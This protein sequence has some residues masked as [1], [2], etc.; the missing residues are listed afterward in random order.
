MRIAPW[1]AMAITLVVLSA[2]HDDDDDLDTLCR[3]SMVSWDLDSRAPIWT[4]AIRRA[5]RTVRPATVID[6]GCGPFREGPYVSQVLLYMGPRGTYLGVDQ[7][8]ETIAR[9]AELT[10]GAARVSHSCGD[11]L[12]G[13]WP[14][15]DLAITKCFVCLFYQGDQ[16]PVV[17]KIRAAADWWLFYD[18]FNHPDPTSYLRS[19]GTVEF[20]I[21][22]CPGNPEYTRCGLLKF[23]R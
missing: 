1:V 10:R 23:L 11:F 16:A 18:S 9:H 17:E 13:E 21:E 4:D 19:L 7:D 12:A 2:N 8:S 3:C 22:R 15:H 14:R 20:V 5:M 6:V